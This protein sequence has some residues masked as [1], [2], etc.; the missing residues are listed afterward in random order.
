MPITSVQ[1]Q[2]VRQLLQ[3]RVGKHRRSSGQ[4][5]VEGLNEMTRALAAG[6][7]VEQFVVC[8][9]LLQP[10]ATKLLAK[11]QGHR[12]VLD[13]SPSVYSRLAMREGSFGLLAVCQSKALASLADLAEC[14]FIVILEGLEKP[15]NLG[16]ILRTAVAAG[17]EAII[18][19]DS[20]CDICH[21]HV[22][23]ASLG[24]CFE[25]PVIACGREKLRSYCQGRGFSI[26]GAVVNS[27]SLDYGKVA[28]KRPCALLLGS[29][30]SGLSRFWDSCCEPVHIPMAGSVDSLNVS[31]ASALLMYKAGEKYPKTRFRQER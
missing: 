17:V 3:L 19:V 16:A 1:N 10:R 7:A 13:V 14:D 15:G 26:Y 6:Y 5:L 30:A 31:V 9:E 23:R 27:S 29:E 20:A 18:A 28:Y 8:R 21:P 25:I 24:A 22:I 4:F 2:R 12:P 11:H